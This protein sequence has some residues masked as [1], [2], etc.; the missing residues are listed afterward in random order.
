M[1][2]YIPGKNMRFRESGL[3]FNISEKAEERDDKRLHHYRY[4]RMGK[5]LGKHINISPM[6]PS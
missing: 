1:D 2:G 4:P 5:T 6:P 3:V